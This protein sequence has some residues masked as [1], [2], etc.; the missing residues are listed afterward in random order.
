MIISEKKR[1][2]LNIVVT[3]LRALFAMVCG[4]FTGR[5]LL[6][7]LGKIDLGLYGVVGGMTYFMSFLSWPITSAVSRFYAYSVGQ[8][9][10]DSGHGVEECQ[11]W[12][13]T[14]LFLLVVLPIT[15]VLLGYPLGIYTIMHWLTIPYERINPCLWVW[16][17]AC[18]NCI[19]T[20]MKVPFYSMFTAKQNIAELTLCTMLETI[21]NVFLLY[22]MVNHPGDW[23]ARYAGWHFIS[24]FMITLLVSIIAICIFPECKFNYKYLINKERINQLCKYS[25]WMLFGCIGAL[26]K[27]QGVAILVNKLFKPV[28]NTAMTLANTISGHSNTLSASITTAFAPAITNACGSREY[29]KMRRYVNLSCKLGSYFVLIFII[30]LLCELNFVLNLW[31]KSPPEYVEGLTICILITLII[32]RSSSGYEIAITA[33]GKI[34]FYQIC[35]GMIVILTLPVAWIMCYFKPIV[36]SVGYA[37]ILMKFLSVIVSVYCAQRLA[38]LSFVNWIIKVLIPIFS[39]CTIGLFVGYLMISIMEQS[40]LRLF[41][42]SLL[43]NIVLLCATITLLFDSFEKQQIYKLVYDKVPFIGRFIR[44]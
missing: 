34:A 37:L 13:N 17:F 38:G 35:T 24:V 25:G 44:I 28:A 4:I 41:L 6:M 10:L 21:L 2:F 29:E 32:E 42:N 15:L 23:L 39:I 7:S 27:T 11:K 8:A 30:P 20:M 40:I 9:K 19:L 33:F 1:I 26:A 5:W 16:R 22:Y 14:A 36:Y 12:F 18:A 31:L 3:Y 43:I